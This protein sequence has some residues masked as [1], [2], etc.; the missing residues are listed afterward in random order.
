MDG[1][2]QRVDAGRRHWA[3]IFVMASGFRRAESGFHRKPVTIRRKRREPP[4]AGSLAFAHIPSEFV[5]R[6]N[7][8]P[9]RRIPL[10][11]QP[12]SMELAPAPACETR[13]PP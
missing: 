11:R 7:G 6:D 12:A 10:H 1:R 2:C 8:L 5:K 9:A 4:L 13:F 3:G